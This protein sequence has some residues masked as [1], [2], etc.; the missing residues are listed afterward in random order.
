MTLAPR[1]EAGKNYAFVANKPPLKS[2]P[3]IA[4]VARVSGSFQFCFHP[5]HDIV[6]VV[7][8]SPLV[9]E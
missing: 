1:L 2:K 8:R 9:L 4:K 3:P 6:G 7:Q 5:T